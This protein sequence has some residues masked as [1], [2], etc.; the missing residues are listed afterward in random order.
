MSSRTA[1]Y[2]AVAL[3]IVTT[4]AGCSSSEA[5]AAGT[6]DG[7]EAQVVNVEIAQAVNHAFVQEIE[8]PS[9]ILPLRKVVIIP[10][11]PGRLDKVLV[12]A[13]DHVTEGQVVAE[14]DRRDYL[15]AVRQAQAAR[16]AASTGVKLASIASESAATT[17]GRMDGLRKSGAITQSDMDKVDTGHRMGLAK[18]DAAHAQAQ[19]AHVGLAA[20]KTKLADTVMRAPFAGVVLQRLLDEGAICSVMPPSPVLVIAEVDT[21]KVEG[22]VAERDRLSIKVGMPARVVV[23]ALRGKVL[24]GVITIINPM[25]DPRTRTAKV[26]INLPN[27]GYVLETGMSARVMLDLGSRMA[28]AVPDE[29]VLRGGAAE[30]VAL[31]VVDEAGVARRREVVTGVRSDGLVEITQGLAAGERVIRA[32]HVGLLD[33]TR[34]Q[35]IETVGD[36]PPPATPAAATVQ[37][38]A[39]QVTPPSVPPVAAPTIPAAPVVST[40]PVGGSV[41]ELTVGEITV[42]ARLSRRLVRRAVESARGELLGC[43]RADLSRDSSTNSRTLSITLD[44]DPDGTV[45]AASAT[46]AGLLAPCV[47]GVLRGLRFPGFPGGGLERATVGL[48]FAPGRT[49]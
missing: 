41:G 7:R 25:V 40:P 33:G 46:P 6:P 23:D 2:L 29:V 30:R 31:F 18:L 44:M 8:I 16:S 20:A 11:V 15:L 13:G 43:Y 28:I 35:I 9:N 5:G 38:A 32:G 39:P 49:S 36:A 26:Q 45:G 42:G 4:S 24:T 22:A 3:L 27:P 1:S 37:P 21:M 10:R 34:V 14:L 47:E 48:A 12:N 17:H 19:L